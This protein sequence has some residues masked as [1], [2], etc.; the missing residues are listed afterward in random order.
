MDN[1]ASCH[2]AVAWKR[3]SQQHFCTVCKWWWLFFCC[4]SFFFTTIEHLLFLLVTLQTMH[5]C[6]ATKCI[7]TYQ[8]DRRLSNGHCVSSGERVVTFYQYTN[9]PKRTCK[10]YRDLHTFTVAVV[11]L[12]HRRVSLLHFPCIK[13]H[14]ILAQIVSRKQQQ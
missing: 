10:F 4:W 14:R 6:N 8:C 12:G 7:S 5:Q 2:F 3:M 9:T 11:N 1:K 13:V